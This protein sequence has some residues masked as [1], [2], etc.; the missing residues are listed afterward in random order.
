MFVNKLFTCLTGAYLKKQ[1]VFLC[2]IFNIFWY[3][4]KVPLRFR[5]QEA[6]QFFLNILRESEFVLA[7]ALFLNDHYLQIHSVHTEMKWIQ[8]IVLT[9]FKVLVSFYTPWKHHKTR[10]SLSF[11]GSM[12]KCQW[13]GRVKQLCKHRHL[14][15]F[16][17]IHVLRCC[18]ANLGICQRSGHLKSSCYNQLHQSLVTAHS[19][20]YGVH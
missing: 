6:V 3:E 4:G 19:I 1:K 9:Q 13:Q 14:Y 10:G 15:N 7:K 18:E 17:V 8:L 12:K 11:S 16:T 2:E 20:T 5:K